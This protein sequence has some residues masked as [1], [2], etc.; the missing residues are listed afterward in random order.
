[1][2]FSPVRLLPL[3][4][5]TALATSDRVIYQGFNSGNT[6]PDWSAK[7]ESDFLK[8][9]STF[10]KLANSPGTFN[11]VRLYTNIQAYTTD[12]PLSAFSAAIATNTSILLGIWCSGT[13][14][15]TSE[16][17]ALTTALDR[18]GSAF[19]DLV[20]AISVGSEDLYR[21]S[22]IG[23]KDGAGIGTGPENIVRFINDTRTAIQGTLL[24]NK[25]VGHV[26]TWT[27]WVNESNTAVRRPHVPAT[28]PEEKGEK[29]K[30]L[31]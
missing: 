11:S 31:T 28:R 25:P 29:K 5:A 23:E 13:T 24:E 6:L 9:F 3:L 2:G 16:L 22:A 18:Y 12:E 26:D 20:L 15:I 27:S 10:P 30:K 1:M 17:K 21:G 8:E 7:N 19:A 14:N 4:A